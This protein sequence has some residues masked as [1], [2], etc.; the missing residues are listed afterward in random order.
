MKRQT[1]I[2][3]I[4]AILMATVLVVLAA[5]STP[6][7]EAPQATPETIVV[8]R[9]VEVQGETVVEEVIITATPEPEP[10][11]PVVEEGPPPDEAD[12]IPEV[13]IV[14]PSAGY[15]PARWEASLLMT[16]AW[17]ELGR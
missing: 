1:R 9:V 4:M 7:P 2:W 5:C 12:L 6:Q 11:E 16:A 15:D 8:T 13:H 3:S 17:Q 14:A 10:E